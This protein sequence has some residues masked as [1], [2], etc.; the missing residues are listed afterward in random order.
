LNLSFIFNTFLWLYVSCAKGFHGG[1]SIHA[2]I[3]FGLYSPPLLLF[4]IP[5]PT[6]SP[7]LVFSE[8]HHVVFI[9]RY[10]VLYF[11]IIFPQL[12]LFLSPLLLLVSLQADPHLYVLFVIYLSIYLSIYH[13]SIYHLSNTLFN[14][15]ICWWVPRLIT[16]LGYYKKCCSKHLCA[17]IAILFWLAI[18][19]IYAQ[20][21]YSIWE[22]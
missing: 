15:F 14:P 7:F 13:L 22:F 12:P 10:N 5:I 11:D 16:L 17:G 6:W 3:A 19:W 20:E 4:H 2:W 21:W 18:L 8:F 1:I 9:H